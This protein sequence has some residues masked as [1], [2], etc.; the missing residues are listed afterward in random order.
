[1]KSI[2]SSKDLFEMEEKQDDDDF[3]WEESKSKEI[4]R[5]SS[6][7]GEVTDAYQAAEVLK[8]SLTEMGDSII[9]LNDN[10]DSAD[11][12][13]EETPNGN[14]VVSVFRLK[15]LEAQMNESLAEILPANLEETIQHVR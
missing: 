4:V 1:M 13:N 12:T 10:S 14:K 11:K 3:Y 7:E 8:A 2:E 15:L 9:E 6:F 5:I